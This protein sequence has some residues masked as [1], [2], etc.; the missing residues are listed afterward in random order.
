ML[1]SKQLLAVFL[2]QG[3]SGNSGTVIPGIY[4]G[5]GAQ[6]LSTGT[7]SSIGSITLNGSSQNGSGQEHWGIGIEGNGTK[8]AAVDADIQITGNGGNSSIFDLGILMRTGAAIESTGT[9][10]NAGNITLNG[11]GASSSSTGFGV[12]IQTNSTTISAID[13]DITMNGNVQSG[14]TSQGISLSGI[15]ETTGEGNLTLNGTAVDSGN[16]PGVSIGSSGIV[17]ASGTGD[18]TL[19]GTGFGSAADISFDTLSLTKTGGTTTFNGTIE[20]NTLT[21]NAGAYDVIFNDGGTIANAVSFNN[22]GTLTLGD[23]TNDSITF[24]NGINA[25]AVGHIHLAGTLITNNNALTLGSTT[26]TDNAVVN[27]G[28]GDITFTESVD[29]AFAFTVNSTGIVNLNGAIGASIALSGLTFLGL[30]SAINIGGD[31]NLNDASVVFD[32]PLVLNDLASFDTGSG[33][34]VFNSTIDDDGN[35]ATASIFTLTSDGTITI[36]DTV[37]GIVTIDRLEVNGNGTAEI[38]ADLNVSGGTLLFN[39]DVLLT[40]TVSFNDSGVSGIFFNGSVD[41]DGK[42]DHGLT[43][44]TSG[45]AKTEFNGMVGDNSALGSLT[46]SAAGVTAINGGVVVTTGEQ[47]YQDAVILG[48]DTALSSDALVTFNE[49]LD[50]GRAN[51]SLT[52]Q[53]NITFEDLVGGTSSLGNLSI[54]GNT[55]MNGGSIT[56]VGAQSYER[57]VTLGADTMLTSASRTNQNLMLDAEVTFNDTVGAT[58]ALAGL[59]TAAN[60]TT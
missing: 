26:L 6:I 19:N 32:S 30:P 35:S 34:L 47:M 21:V 9:G 51:S 49:T 12:R 25:S 15:I 29:G 40:N 13:G 43:L 60:N 36:N 1:I 42:E 28:N 38:G 46:T 52:V 45:T 14:G 59:T 2:L 44:A 39:T 57:L 56:T 7:G 31:I 27:S 24:N 11:T 8:I 55:R 17:R 18:L 53:G 48:K 5:G 23:N 4:L 3:L 20:G 54:T 22:M 16:N 41:G 58:D 37:G 50:G 33:D 10:P